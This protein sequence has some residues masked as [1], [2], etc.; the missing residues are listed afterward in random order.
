[1]WLVLEKISFVRYP[2]RN[3]SVG[4]S[5]SV[6]FTPLEIEYSKLATKKRKLFVQYSYYKSRWGLKFSVERSS[7][8]LVVTR[9]R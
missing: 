9:I 7:A 8:G 1:M 6:Q 3:L 5:F 4:E 2:W